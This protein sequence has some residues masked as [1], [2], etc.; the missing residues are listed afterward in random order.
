MKDAIVFW[1][2]AATILAVSAL[3]AAYPAGCTPQQRAEL[4]VD[5]SKTGACVLTAI[6]E[7]GIED[8]SLLL[9]RCEGSTL[10]IIG[11]VVKEWLNASAVQPDAAHLVAAS[12]VHVRFELVAQRT[13]TALADGG[14]K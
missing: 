12:P 1:G 7:G 11:A 6:A 4:A 10:A 8:P 13:Q 14:A 2:T 9:T 5:L 3:T